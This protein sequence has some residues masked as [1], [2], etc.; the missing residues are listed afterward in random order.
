[1]PAGRVTAAHREES[2]PAAQPSAPQVPYVPHTPRE[3]PAPYRPAAPDRGPGR[4]VRILAGVREE[5]LDWIPAWRPYYTGLGCIVLATSCLAAL[6]MFTALTKIVSAPALVLVPIALFWGWIIMTVDRWLIIST[7]GDSGAG[8]DPKAGHN[9]TARRLLIFLPRIVLAAVVALTIAEP[10]ILMVFQPTLTRQVHQTQQTQLNELTSKLTLCN[11]TTGQIVQKPACNGYRLSLPNPPGAVQSELAADQDRQNQLQTQVNGILATINGLTETAREECAGI[12][13]PGLSG[14][15]GQG[16]D[17]RQDRQAVT[18][19]Q[20]SSGLAARQAELATLGSQISKLTGGAEAANNGY[21][22]AV[23]RAI[24]VRVAQWRA[25]QRGTIGLID[26]WQALEV[27]AA[28]STFVTFAEWLIRAILVILDTLPVVA[29]MLNGSTPYDRRLDRLVKSDEAIHDHFL[30]QRMKHFTQGNDPV[31]RA[32]RGPHGPRSDPRLSEFMASYP[33]M[34]RQVA[35]DW[36]QELHLRQ[37]RFPGITFRPGHTAPRAA[38]FDGPEVWE[39]HRDFEATR[40]ASRGL[41]TRRDDIIELM[42]STSGRPA[43]G[44]RTALDYASRY[45]AEIKRDVDVANAAAL[46]RERE[47]GS[48]AS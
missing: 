2:R 43:A 22:N 13:G 21:A 46:A 47:H 32:P 18:S 42:A 4:R 24:A 36:L 3:V 38:L 29:K 28:K 16:E 44:I 8:E 35:L 6:A 25:D 27:L 12:A 7:Y 23:S 15:P 37:I 34:S 17:C 5:I 20:N 30:D 10:V 1:V 48:L 26:E 45:P 33:G 9:R 39:V 41:S 31:R 19:Y 40:R 14:I 11:P